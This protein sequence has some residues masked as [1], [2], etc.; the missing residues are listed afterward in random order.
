MQEISCG[1][2]FPNRLNGPGWKE[3][4]YDTSCSNIQDFAEEYIMFLGCCCL[5]FLSLAETIRSSRVLIRFLHWMVKINLNNLL[6]YMHR[7]TQITHAPI[8]PP[9][10]DR[11][12]EVADIERV[13]REVQL[14]KLIRLG[15]SGQYQPLQSPQ[16]LKLLS[17]RRYWSDMLRWLL[18][19][20]FM[21]CSVF[22]GNPKQRVADA[23][24]QIWDWDM[25]KPVTLVKLSKV[26]KQW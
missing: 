21:T 1:R 9:R 23:K 15:R 19:G 12:Q 7:Y 4:N 13:A 16:G 18:C 11:I 25:S 2:F 3:R 5:V 17:A 10:K 22:Q 8:A 24:R 14:L 20:T 26:L 6:T